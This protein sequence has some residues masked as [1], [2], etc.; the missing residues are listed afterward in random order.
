MIQKIAHIGHDRELMKT[1]SLVLRAAGF[2]VEEAYSFGTALTLVEAVDA[3][4]IC[5]TWPGTDKTRLVGAVRDN[6]S[7]IPII[8]VNSYQSQAHPDGCLSADKTPLA[9]L[10]AI[11]AATR[12]GL[13]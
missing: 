5:H 9:I 2:S 6:R 11:A 1:R 12:M 10:D 13:A 3:L 4:L 8:C 7:P